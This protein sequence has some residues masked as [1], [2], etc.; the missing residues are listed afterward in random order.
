[1]CVLHL[2]CSLFIRPLTPLTTFYAYE[3]IKCVGVAREFIF[4]ISNLS[5]YFD[6]NHYSLFITTNKKLECLAT[7]KDTFS[8][9]LMPLNLHHQKL[10]T[11]LSRL[12]FLS[13]VNL[14]FWQSYFWS[15]RKERKEN[16]VYKDKQREGWII[17][18]LSK[19]QKRGCCLRVHGSTWQPDNLMLRWSEVNSRDG[20]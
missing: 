15:S 17:A 6:R 2:F 11:H 9:L 1:M 10:F 14:I 13:L 16:F 18:P 20:S 7:I 12:I 5:L 4:M 3:C 19:E 8:S